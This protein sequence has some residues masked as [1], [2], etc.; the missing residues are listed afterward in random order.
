MRTWCGAAAV[1]VAMAM[2][3]A[4][5]AAAQTS[6]TPAIGSPAVN[7]VSQTSTCDAGALT[8]IDG[9]ISDIFGVFVVGQATAMCGEQPATGTIGRAAP[10]DAGAQ[11]SC[12]TGVV[13]GFYG[14]EGQLV[15]QVGVRCVD[16][17][18]Q[19]DQRP[20]I[21]GEGGRPAGPYDCEPGSVA[22]GLHGTAR[23][24]GTRELMDSLGLICRVADLDGDGVTDDVDTCRGV[25]NPGNADL[26]GD[27]RGDACD[28]DDDG[29]GVDDAADN[30]ATTPNAGQGDLDADGRGDACDQV[31]DRRC[32]VVAP[33]PTVGGLV[34]G[35]G[36]ALRSPLVQRLSCSVPV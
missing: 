8:G 17:S 7:A 14:R 10:G 23:D 9:R 5:P 6:T 33:R 19:V 30:C 31:D 25:D 22:V 11:T 35:L 24:D 12:A 21:G 36:G 16:A 20:A 34:Y 13:A 27:G 4:A 1:M 18:Y 15:D 26:D 28:P 29:D 32:P 3:A 2:A